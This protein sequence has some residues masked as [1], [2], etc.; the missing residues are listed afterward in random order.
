MRRI[1]KVIPTQWPG[2]ALGS[3]QLVLWALICK[4][5]PFATQ[6]SETQTGPAPVGRPLSLIQTLE[7]RIWMAFMDG[8]WDAGILLKRFIL[9]CLGLGLGKIRRNTILTRNLKCRNQRK[10]FVANTFK[11]GL[12]I[13]P[14]H[15]WDGVVSALCSMH[16][17][18]RSE[19]ER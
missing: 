6:P 1:C 2:A 9:W 19:I 12:N 7:Q 5:I 17:C 8:S 16:P 4:V 18:S 3:P 13:Q 14:R 15:E 11:S 10:Y